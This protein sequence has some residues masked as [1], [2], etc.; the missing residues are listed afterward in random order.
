M[1]IKTFFLLLII[2]L[3]L[4]AG[5]QYAGFSPFL[6]TGELIFQQRDS[7]ALKSEQ[8]EITFF[9]NKTAVRVTYQLEQKDD[10]A[11]SVHCALPIHLIDETQNL[12]TYIN[13]AHSL[14]N[15]LFKKYRYN[16]QFFNG[17]FSH[18]T[19]KCNDT[20]VT[21]QANWHE[22]EDII[23][24]ESQLPITPGENS[25][26][27]SYELENHYF[28]TQFASSMIPGFS[29][30][31]FSYD[32]SSASCWGEKL[33]DSLS[34]RIFVRGD[35]ALFFNEDYTL[36]RMLKKRF[37][38]LGNPYRVMEFS[39]EQVLLSNLA[40]L[41]LKADISPIL[42]TEHLRANKLTIPQEAITFTSS[43]AVKEH[44]LVHLTDGNFATG[45]AI[46]GGKG[47]WIEIA[48]DTSKIREDITGIYLLNGNWKSENH[49]KANRRIKT[50]KVEISGT[51]CEKDSMSEQFR[52]NY[53]PTDTLETDSTF[54]GNKVIELFSHKG[55]SI[56]KILRCKITV[57]DLL[58]GKKYKDLILSEIIITGKEK[59]GNLP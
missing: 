17:L 40:Q 29:E 4:Y 41:T 49:Y 3:L 43:K 44:T 1:P 10:S 54:Y 24:I 6:K 46:S 21:V 15:F 42:R 7:L 14:E 50:A 58:A 23:F 39:M 57:Q 2:T 33:V 45:V 9:G 53:A 16:N 18:F 20:T 51:G 34:M 13:G 48:I 38:F 26:T 22:S 30:R 56:D 32:F 12:Y 31:T 25:I 35:A 36:P 27:L 28:D 19:L 11:S 37:D 5:E 47:N 59:K 55:S 8:L 52:V